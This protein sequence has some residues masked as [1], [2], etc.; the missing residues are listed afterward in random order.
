MVNELQIQ[1]LMLAA[2]LGAWERKRILCEN[3]QA[4]FPELVIHPLSHVGCWYEDSTQRTCF[5]VDNNVYRVNDADPRLLNRSSGETTPLVVLEEMFR[6]GLMDHSIAFY[7]RD[8][9]PPATEDVL[10]NGADPSGVLAHGSGEDARRTWA[11][12]R[13]SSRIVSRSVLPKAR[14]EVV[15]A[16][17]GLSLT[18]YELG[19]GTLYHT[20][21]ID[22][23][24]NPL[25]GLDFLFGART[26]SQAVDLHAAACT[27]IRVNTNVH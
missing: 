26:H 17:L 4:L 12:V 6:N 10:V 22:Q 27:R 2:F 5:Q 7:T 14:L 24:G 21:A 25:S 9:R 13:P 8:H 23:E 18:A 20:M 16:L 11:A 15:T 1:R 3:I 19:P